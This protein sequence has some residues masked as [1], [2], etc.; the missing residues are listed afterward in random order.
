MVERT[1]LDPWWTRLATISGVGLLVR[2]GFVFGVARFD[3]PVGDQL[4]Y[5]AQAHTNAMGHWFE[6]PFMAG[7]PAADHPPLTSMLLTPVSW[8]FRNTD[9]FITA[10]RLVMVVIGVV[11][12]VVMGLVGRV[13]GGDRTGL[14]AAAITAV[15]ANVWVN[16]GLLMAE[17]PTFLLVS[18]STLVA[19]RFRREPGMVWLA[20]SGVLSGLLALTRAELVVV[21]PLMMVLAAVH[22]PGGATDRIRR[23]VLVPACAFVVL[24]PWVLWN[25]A[26]FDGS[27]WLSTNDGLTIAG[28][29]C[30]HTYYRDVGS[31][32]IWCAYAVP[33]PDGVDASVESARMRAAGFDYWSDHLSRYPVVA[34]ARL[35]RVTST[36]F[37]GSNNAAGLSEGRPLWVSWLGIGQY[38]ILVV[39]AAA[40]FRR[41][42]DHS[43]RTIL[44]ALMPVVLVVALVA[45]A[46]VRFRLPAEVGLVA[47][48]A[49]AIARRPAASG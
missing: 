47:L 26:R 22:G 34:G 6:Q 15:Y 9:S 46:Y 24:A 40:G 4:Y 35:L 5:S 27:V 10:Q 3:E 12:I 8:V 49:L 19:L 42:T 33:V 25:Q 44:V 7:T 21:I 43:D 45:N 1:R 2:L 28:A 20:V 32:D 18:L 48:A 29:N 16:D 36:G 38:W 31:W 23:A 41:L 14:V 11:S 37:L 17:S 39:A 13:L 30:D